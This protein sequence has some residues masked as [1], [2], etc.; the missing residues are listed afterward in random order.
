MAPEII[1]GRTYNGSEAE[2]FSLGVILCT[3]VTGSLPFLAAA[4]SDYFYSLLLT[5]QTDTFFKLLDQRSG[6]NLSAEFKDLL[7]K[8]FSYKGS[9]RPT[10]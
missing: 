8:F 6:L 1:E 2:I 10:F 3:I 7:T 9:D 4:K 5:G